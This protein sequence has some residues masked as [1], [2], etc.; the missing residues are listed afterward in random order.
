MRLL[1]VEYMIYFF[2]INSIIFKIVQN[3]NFNQAKLIFY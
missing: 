2:E 1:F 3:I